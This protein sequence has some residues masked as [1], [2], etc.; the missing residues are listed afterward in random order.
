MNLS[1]CNPSYSKAIEKD[2]PFT[3][4][5]ALYPSNSNEP[6]L[7]LEIP[8]AILSVVFGNGTPKIYSINFRT[9]VSHLY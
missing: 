5:L 7:A 8:Y 3:I 4:T 9:A 2:I 6:P 1:C